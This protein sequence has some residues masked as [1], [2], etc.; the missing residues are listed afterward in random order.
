MD[1]GFHPV[2]VD[3]EEVVAVCGDRESVG[4]FGVEAGEGV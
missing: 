4:C 2:D 3:A 1:C